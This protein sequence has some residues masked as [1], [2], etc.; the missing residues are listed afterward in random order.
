MVIRVSILVCTLLTMSVALADFLPKTFSSQFEQNYTSSLKGRE[1]SGKGSIEYKYPGHIRFETD[2]PST[3]TFVSNGKKTWYYRAPFIEGEQGEVTESSIAEGTNIYIKFFDSLNK[4]LV[5]N[6]LYSVKLT[7]YAELTFS[8]K[9]KGELSISEANIYF[10]DNKI[11]KFEDV[12]KI[13]LVLT[14]N[15]KTTIKFLDLKVN[16]VISEEKF[17]FSPPKNTKIVN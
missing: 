10:K 6:A 15:K 13:E 14:D 7:N 16:P 9:L 3:V 8:E 1:K 17:N 5:N 4:G 11:G 12:E 2:A